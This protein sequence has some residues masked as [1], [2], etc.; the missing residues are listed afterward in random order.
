MSSL[1]AT[2]QNTSFQAYPSK[3]NQILNTARQY[4]SLCLATTNSLKAVFEV[5]CVIS[6]VLL[7]HFDVTSSVLY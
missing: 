4:P 2:C 5:Y 1:T 6:V 7:S 3:D